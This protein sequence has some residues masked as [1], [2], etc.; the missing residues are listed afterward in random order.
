[1]G[2][3][4]TC[5]WDALS[6]SMKDNLGDYDRAVPHHLILTQSY[7]P[8]K[9]L[10]LNFGNKSGMLSAIPYQKGV[11]SHSGGFFCG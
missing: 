5:Q 9:S 4:C 7:L 8:W 10:I 2:L 1:M 6:S 3:V 11:L